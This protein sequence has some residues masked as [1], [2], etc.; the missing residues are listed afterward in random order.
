MLKSNKKKKGL[1]RKKR[2]RKNQGRRKKRRRIKNLFPLTTL[3]K[4]EGEQGGEASKGEPGEQEEALEDNVHHNLFSDSS[5]EEIVIAMR[6]K[7]LSQF[8]GRVGG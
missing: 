6:K 3:K 8:R 5:D 4:G 7:R 1:R 2:K